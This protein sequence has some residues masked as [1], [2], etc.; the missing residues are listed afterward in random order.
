MWRVIDHK[1]LI[2]G[3]CPLWDDRRGLLYTMDIRGKLVRC[4]DW[5][6]NRHTQREYNQE[7]GSIAL[8]ESGG[9]LLAMVD[10]IYIDHGN[11]SLELFAKP[12]KMMGRRFND[13]KVGP[14]GRFYVGTTDYHG[15]GAFY[16]LDHDGRM[17]MLF[18]DVGCSNGIDWDLSGRIMYYCDSPKKKLEAFDFDPIDGTLSGR[19]TVI[20][21]PLD[22]GE[23]DGMCVD[24]E[25]MLWVAVWGAGCTL[26]IDP[27][28]AK[29]TG[30]FDFPVRRISCTAFAGPRLDTLILTSAAYQSENDGEELAGCTFAAHAGSSGLPTR[31]FKL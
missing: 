19:R 26:K 21:L 3:E 10:G 31:R 28:A 16:R 2:V 15:K 17:Q 9:L 12:N 23:F 25:G 8:T 14:D 11:G 5:A 30:R 13:G 4:Y 7:I 1:P 20:T 22:G 24:S 27:T 6:E 18:E 29:V